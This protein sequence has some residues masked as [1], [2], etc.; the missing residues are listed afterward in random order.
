MPRHGKESK[1]RTLFLP[2]LVTLL[3]M[4]LS[5]PKLV[6]ALEAVDTTMSVETAGGK[7]IKQEINTDR[8]TTPPTGITDPPVDNPNGEQQ[9]CYADN[10]TGCLSMYFD[11]RNPVSKKLHSDC[12][13]TMKNGQYHYMCTPRDGSITL[14]FSK[15][16]QVYFEL[17]STYYMVFTSY[18]KNGVDNST[19]AQ[20][21]MIYYASYYLIQQG[22]GCPQGDPTNTC[23]YTFIMNNISNPLPN[24]TSW[25][26]VQTKSREYSDPVR[27]FLIMNPSYAENIK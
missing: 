11:Y 18:Y 23:I 24:G 19:Y 13:P 16:A 10:I 8:S 7:D 15:I 4:A 21:G 14:P 27:E 22:P 1:T 2:L 26:D 5:I 3:V 12:E 17:A 9:R 25:A 20:E 6:Q